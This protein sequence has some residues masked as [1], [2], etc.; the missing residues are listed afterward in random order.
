[1]E[2]SHPE[3]QDRMHQRSNAPEVSLGAQTR[4]PMATHGLVHV[5]RVQGRAVE[6][7]QPHVADDHKPERVRRVLERLGSTSPPDLL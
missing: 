6:A 7:G 5:H 4:P 1:M 2:R 3:Q